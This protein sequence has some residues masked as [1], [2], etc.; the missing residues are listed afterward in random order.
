MS[1]LEHGSLPQPLPTPEADA[2]YERLYVWEWPIRLFHWVNA[3]AITVL[4]A[5]GLMIA[6]P[7]LT[8]T[9][10]PFE[11]S[12]MGT[13]RMVHFAAAYVMLVGFLVRLY[14][15]L[16]GN[17]HARSG[18]PYFWRLRWW[19]NLWRQC[20]DY[21]KFDFGHPHLGHNALAGLSYVVLVIGLGCLQM[22]TGFAMLS[23]SD[24]QGF[25]GSLV[26]WVIPLCGGSAHVHQWHHLFAWGFAVFVVL[27]LYI[28]FLDARQ[29]R[30]GLIMSIITGFKF[31]RIGQRSGEEEDEAD[32]A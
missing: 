3:L 8:A 5:T 17:V 10:E 15:F 9:G 25:W 13:I 22:A 16:V 14:W 23:E 21:L 7:A 11:V 18:F 32:D 6:D 29:Y 28:V 20:L 19:R 24:P 2:R 27:H 31:R 1:Q 4:F 26:G 12:V 30:N